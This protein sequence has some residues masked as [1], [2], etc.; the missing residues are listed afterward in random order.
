MFVRAYLNASTDEQDANRARQ[1][2]KAF[3]AEH[4]LSIAAFYVENESG[5]ALACP[6]DILLVEQVD[7][8]S[9]LNAAD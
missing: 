6:G 2:V 3:A 8:L 5:A 9:R 1:H 7:R 4:G